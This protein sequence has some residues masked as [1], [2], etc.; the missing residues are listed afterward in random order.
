MRIVTNTLLLLVCA[1][2]LS[3]GSGCAGKISYNVRGRVIDGET[4]KPVEGAAVA[5]NWYGFRRVALLWTDGGTVSF[6]Q[7]EDLSD[8][9]GYFEIPKYWATPF[10]MGVYKKGYVCWGNDKIF[11]GWERRK[12]FSLEN[13]MVI[14]LEPFKES[15]SEKD[16]ARFTIFREN[17]CN[18]RGSVK[19][20]FHNAIKSEKFLFYQK[21]K[22]EK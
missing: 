8:K 6:E 5:V 11:P 1:L 4:G 12:D 19:S 20:K 10:Y 14:K 17:S 18:S 21:E 2:L 16:H 15:Y 7:A 13:G 3:S 22:E 9:E